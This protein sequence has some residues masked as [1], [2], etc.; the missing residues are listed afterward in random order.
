MMI[1]KLKFQLKEI[2]ENVP[3][4]ESNLKKLPLPLSLS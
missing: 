1:I 3:L 4:V 2:D